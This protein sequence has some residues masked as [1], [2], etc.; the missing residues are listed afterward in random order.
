M[1][2]DSILVIAL[3]LIALACFPLL[4]LVFSNATPQPIA[5]IIATETPTTVPTAIVTATPTVSLSPTPF[6]R[7]YLLPFRQVFAIGQ[8]QPVTGTT[9]LLYENGT[10]V[11]LLI[12]RQD[13]YAHLQ[14]PDGKLSFWTAAENVSTGSPAS[15]QYDLSGRGKTIR[16]VPSVGYACLHEDA[17]PP[18]FSTCKPSPDFSSAKLVAK[19]TSGSVTMYLVEIDGKNY[20]MP[21]E[22]VLT[23]P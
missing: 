22:T 5:Q 10:D 2:R 3:A 16:L 1:K 18:T 17:P 11:F 15:A 20:Y 7:A 14:T 21:P 13:K 12:G 6:P 4:G 9:T 19:I 23:I 8:S